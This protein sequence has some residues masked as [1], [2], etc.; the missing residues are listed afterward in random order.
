MG[1]NGL[2]AEPPLTSDLAFERRWSVR[3][4]VGTR[5]NALL[6]AIALLVVVVTASALVISFASAGG[7]TPT[8]GNG[9]RVALLLVL[10]IGSVGVA[11]AWRLWRVLA[12]DGHW[13]PASPILPSLVEDRGQL[14]VEKYAGQCPECGAKL[15]FYSRPVRW[16]YEPDE[17]GRHAVVD[18]RAP[19]AECRTDRRHWW[20][21]ERR[22]PGSTAT[23]PGPPT[24]SGR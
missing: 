9:L 16:H 13:V 23:E 6:G 3:L 11:A 10:A 8:T 4:R 1:V 14:L 22:A 15:R 24:N 2:G 21:I 12:R 17:A 5:S 20:T 18:E 19:A 7:A